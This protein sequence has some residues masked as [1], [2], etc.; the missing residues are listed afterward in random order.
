[1]N[2]IKSFIDDFLLIGTSF[3]LDLYFYKNNLNV[4][5]PKSFLS[6]KKYNKLSLKQNL[7]ILNLLIEIEQRKNILDSKFC[8][9]FLLI[10]I[11]KELQIKKT[12]LE[13]I[14]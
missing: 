5:F 1:M 6:K 8:F 2:K 10:Q 14:C 3:F 9:M 13:M 11:E 7:K 4:I 12:D